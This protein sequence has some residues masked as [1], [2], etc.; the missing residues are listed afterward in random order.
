MFGMKL[1]GVHEPPLLE[2][3]GKTA[4]LPQPSVHVSD[5]S[6]QLVARALLSPGAATKL[7]STR[8]ADAMIKKHSKVSEGRSCCCAS[9]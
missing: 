5:R 3:S 4:P 2:Q 8:R 7:T 1:K 6:P 9:A